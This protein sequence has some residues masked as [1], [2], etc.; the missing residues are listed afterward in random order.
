MT[1]RTYVAYAVALTLLLSGCGPDPAGESGDAEMEATMNQGKAEE[2]VEELITE[3][4]A[5]LPDSLE[6]ESLGGITANPCDDLANGG[7][8]GPVSVGRTYWLDGLPVEENEADVELLLE[9]WT[10]NGYRVTDDRRPEQLSVFVEDEEDSF[11]M[12]VQ[13]S[14]QGDLSISAS[15]PCVWPEGTPEA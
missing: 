11:R 9:F 14:V 10:D 6:L 5:V 13:S 3:A 15:S 8:E 1:P 12:S 7:A 4:T 2:R